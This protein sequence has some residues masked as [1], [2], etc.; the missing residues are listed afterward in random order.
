MKKKSCSS[1]IWYDPHFVLISLFPA[2]L[3][4]LYHWNWFKLEY[5]SILYSETLTERIS[6]SSD[7]QLSKND[8]NISHLSGEHYFLLQ[9]KLEKCHFNNEINYP[10]HLYVVSKIPYFRDLPWLY[11]CDVPTLEP[12][13]LSTLSFLSSCSTLSQNIYNCRSC[14]G[15]G[16]SGRIILEMHLY[17]RTGRI[18]DVIN[19]LEQF[20]A[21][22]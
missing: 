17:Y 14:W 15:Y 6:D 4:F 22:Q 21:R 7:P 13:G 8:T 20:R 9:L 19:L 11:N 12:G 16:S 1:D 3:I 2:F 18:D 10:L 5:I